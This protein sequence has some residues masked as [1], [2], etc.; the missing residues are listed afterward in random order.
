MESLIDLLH[1]DDASTSDFSSVLAEQKEP[2]SQ[3]SRSSLTAIQE[4]VT[5]TVDQERL[6]LSP[7]KSTS[8]IYIVTILSIFTI[9][10]IMTII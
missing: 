5:D 3:M 4:N 1:S 2:T 7:G 6:T 8:I 9:I 10:N